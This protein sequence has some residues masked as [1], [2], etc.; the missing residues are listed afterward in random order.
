M[1][2]TDIIRDILELIDK[3]E[4]EQIDAQ[5]VEMGSFAQL[6]AQMSAT[7]QYD[8]SPNPHTQGVDSVTI[9][10]GGGWNGPK[11]PSDL[12]G[13][14]ISLYPNFQAKDKE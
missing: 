13:N 12:R 6:F 8:N 10:A 3:I 2:A 4:C 11:Q 9:N 1:R 14:S 7:P 5:S